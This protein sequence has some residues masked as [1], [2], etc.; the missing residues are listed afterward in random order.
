[1]VQTAAAKKDDRNTFFCWGLTFLLTCLFWYLVLFTNLSAPI[2]AIPGVLLL[3]LWV[4]EIR[5][6]CRVT[7]HFRY[8]LGH[9]WEY[10]GKVEFFI[11]G[12][13]SSLVCSVLYG[14]IFMEWIFSMLD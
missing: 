10:S 6:I 8:N 7:V 13:L 12:F 9:W 3:L 11:I 14:P 4:T 2:L 1:M 5:W